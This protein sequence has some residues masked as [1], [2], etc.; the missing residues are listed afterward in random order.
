MENLSSSESRQQL[1][2]DLLSEAKTV[3][4]LLTLFSLL[5]VWETPR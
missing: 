1:F 2:A 5:E 3:D 4:K